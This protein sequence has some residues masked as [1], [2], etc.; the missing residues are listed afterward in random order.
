VETPASRR[1]LKS[2]LAR[3]DAHKVEPKEYEELPQLTD[4][5]L[6]RAKVNRGRGP[7]SP[8]HADDSETSYL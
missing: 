7:P 6:T 2:D 8:A 5:M 3:V 1:S 4:E